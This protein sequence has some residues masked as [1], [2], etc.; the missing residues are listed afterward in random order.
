MK[1]SDYRIFQIK[2]LIKWYKYIYCYIYII[3]IEDCTCCGRST[4]VPFWRKWVIDGFKVVKG[5]KLFWQN[6]GRFGPYSVGVTQ[7]SGGGQN[8][9]HV[10]QI[11]REAIRI[12]KIYS[13]L[14]VG[15]MVRMILETG[16]PKIKWVK[17]STTSDLHGLY[18]KLFHSACTFQKYILLRYLSFHFWNKPICLNANHDCNGRNTQVQNGDYWIQEIDNP[19]NSVNNLNWFCLAYDYSSQIWI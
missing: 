4:Q 9:F 19:R 16:H 7:K 1:Q 15:C 12:T 10:H 11:I 17:F 2:N 8:T 13:S 5:Q 14:C 18:I 3:V 6:F